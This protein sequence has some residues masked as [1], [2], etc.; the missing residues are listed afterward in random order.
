MDNKLSDSSMEI[1][2]SMQTLSVIIPVFN[3]EST[4]GIILRKVS[5]LRTLKEVIV[6]DDGSTDSTP[7]R[8]EELGLPKV[9][10]IK[11]ER[12]LGK[13]AAVRRGLQEVTGDITIFQDA[14]LE[15]DPDEIE[16][17]I[18]PIVENKADIVYG[19]R[20]LVKRATR[21]LYFYHYIAN[22]MLTLFSN[23]LT[24]VNM[25]DIE[26]C[27]KAFRTPLIKNLP[28]TSSGFGIE[29]EI[30]ALATKTKARIYEVP[31]SYYG[32]TYEEGKK[33]KLTDGLI[34]LWYIAYYNLI[35]YI[36]P[37]RRKYIE[38]ANVFLTQWKREGVKEDGIK[39]DID[40]SKLSSLKLADS[41]PSTL[42]ISQ[43]EQTKDIHNPSGK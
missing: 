37:S 11:Q 30:T 23:F 8:I 1:T 10:L 34:A 4:I 17:V 3:E 14:D 22:K 27:Y 2:Q 42:E 5:R 12:N 26:T 18:Q 43:C 13:T 35:S 21:V 36:S 29:V 28:L 39:S 31:I 6:V 40:Y 38:K 32:R 25:S 15:Y 7:Q 33:I 24:N 41:T 19:S 9:R 20:F 16:H